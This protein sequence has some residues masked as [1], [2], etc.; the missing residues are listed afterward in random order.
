MNTYRVPEFTARG[1]SLAESL[2]G[3]KLPYFRV[4][5]RRQHNISDDDRPVE[6]QERKF[7]CFRCE[8]SWPRE[9]F[10]WYPRE[11]G[12]MNKGR[13]CLQCRTAPKPTRKDVEL[14]T[15][16]RAIVTR[17]MS[18]AEFSA[19]CKLVVSKGRHRLEAAVEIGFISRTSIPIPNST[20]CK[21][22]FGPVQQ[23]QKQ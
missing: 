8:K 18:A 15:E 1:P 14:A 2:T 17:P 13:L 9:H 11:G 23:E 7:R 12:G 3:F 22:L 20:R 19:I 10:D 6:Y 21:V 5:G 4:I 16:V